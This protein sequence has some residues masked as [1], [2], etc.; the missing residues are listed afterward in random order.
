MAAV[1]LDHHLCPDQQARNPLNY[2]RLAFDN[3]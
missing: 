2:L 3:Q 1:K